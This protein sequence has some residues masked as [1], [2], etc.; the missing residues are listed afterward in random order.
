MSSYSMF[1]NGVFGGS[2]N[3][4]SLLGGLGQDWA[5]GT[6]AGL[7]QSLALMQYDNALATN[8]SAQRAT[9]SQNVANQGTNEGNHY[10]NYLDNQILSYL[11]GGGNPAAASSPFNQWWGQQRLG[12]LTGTNQVQGTPINTQPNANPTTEVVMPKIVN[13]AGTPVSGLN[14]WR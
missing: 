9:I 10:R 3:F 14:N 12:A 7:Q 6:N 5:S 4:L 11:A 8:P 1:G 2:N 13:A